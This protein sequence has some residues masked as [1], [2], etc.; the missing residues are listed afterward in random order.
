ML[1]KN[2]RVATGVDGT[3]SVS[4]TV[5]AP[6]DPARFSGRVIYASPGGGYGRL[7][8]DMHFTGHEGYSQAAHHVEAGHILVAYDHLGVGE[9]D[10]S[11][12]ST[13]TI[14]DIAD[15]DHAAVQQV[16]DGL[17]AG[18][19]LATYPPLPDA[20][21]IG[22]GQSM[23]G[24]VTIIMQA[25]HRSFDA[26]GVLGYSAI[27]TVLP[28]RTEEQ[29]AAAKAQ[30]QFD[31]H[32]DPAA[33]SV[34]ATAAG[35]ADFIYPFHWEDVPA[36]ILK[37]DMEGGYPIRRTAPPFGSLTIPNCVVAMMGPGFVA[38][39]A[40]VVDVPVFLG[41]GE[42]DTS[43]D[44]REEPSAYTNAGDITLVIVPTMAHMHNFAS[45]RARLW[46]RL[47]HW[48]LGVGRR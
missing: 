48:A 3:R 4:L 41:F 21:H 47:S 19:L 38:R 40:A 45:T 42:R 35:V 39:D 23:G 31:R 14:E 30:Y 28:Q 11:E 13:L 46:D 5:Y 33:L 1:R 29:A 27:H 43:A 9:S 44:F 12:L 8:Y 16:R 25:R 36:D 32:T 24:G 22:I 18:T 15:A 34:A 10:V 7:Y 17:I 6:E 2:M 26:I 20:V 37:A